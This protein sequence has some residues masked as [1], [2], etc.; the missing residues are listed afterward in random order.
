MAANAVE[1][2]VE[3]AWFIAEE[4]AAGSFPWVLAITP[5]YFD[6]AERGPFADRQRAALAGLGVIDD[7]R[8]NPAVVDWVRTVCFP[9]RWLELRFVKPGSPTTK[10]GGSAR[11]GGV[12]GSGASGRGAEGKPGPPATEPGPPDSTAGADL[13][14]GLVAKRGDRVVVA[15]R[16]GGLLTL[17]SM[18]AAHPRD[19]VPIVTVG[20]ARAAPAV[21]PEFALPARV[22]ARADERL[23][24]G[25]GIVET[26][27][28]LGIPRAARPV[29]AAVYGGSRNYAEI[30]AGARGIGTEQTSPVGLGIMDAEPGRILV[31][32]ERADD[33]EWISHF[34]PGTSDAIARAVDDLTATLPD[35]RWFAD[36]RLTRDFTG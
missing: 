28:Y 35:G 29:I 31:R 30:V 21:F 10:P 1:L 4:S 19:L 34:A 14:R 20:L 11:L 32:P 17:T 26:L 15:L 8:I 3:S 27:E 5:P 7:G 6:A 25:V 24:A 13:L 22:G 2:T 23:R 16:S 36:A 33:G 9:D 12:D 18:D